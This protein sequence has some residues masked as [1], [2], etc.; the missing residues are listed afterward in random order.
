[1]MKKSGRRRRNGT[2]ENEMQNNRWRRRPQTEKRAQPTGHCR[3]NT[4]VLF[5]A[6]HA[7]VKSEYDWLDCARRPD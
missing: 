5:R 6:P 2:N 3:A 1:M 7:S 4:Y